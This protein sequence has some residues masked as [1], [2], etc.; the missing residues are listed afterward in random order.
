MHAL[1]L[2]LKLLVE[3]PSGFLR[4]VSIN[5]INEILDGGRW[6]TPR[7]GR[8]IPGNDPVLTIQEARWAA[9]AV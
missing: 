7:G 2:E 1:L 4:A 5:Y 3:D 9:G 6:L 8:F